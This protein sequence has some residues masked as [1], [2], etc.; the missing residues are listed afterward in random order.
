[1]IKIALVDD[2]ALLRSGLSAVITSFG[3]YQVIFEA[4]NGKHFIQQLQ[5]NTDPDVVLLDINMPEMDG[6]ETAKWIKENRPE[7]KILVLSMLDNDASIIRMLRNG[8]RGYM[9]KDSKPEVLRSSLHSI[10]HKGYCTNELVSGKMVHFINKGVDAREVHDLNEKEVQFLRLCC[11]EKSYKEMAS[12]M[13]IAPRTVE[14]LRSSL[15]DK[16]DTTS[17]VGLVLYAIRNGLFKI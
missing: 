15:F 13:N 14:S 12:D 6:F 5:T 17:R 7:I 11:S 2:H 16:L 8:A 1:M 3:H 10:V 4:D 9:L